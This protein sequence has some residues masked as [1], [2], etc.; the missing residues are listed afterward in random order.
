MNFAGSFLLD[1]GREARSVPGVVALLSSLAVRDTLMAEGANGGAIALKWPNDVLVFDK[2]VA[3]ILSS[4]VRQGRDAAFV[5]GIGV[6]L[7][8]A[9]LETVFPAAA[10]FPRGRAPDPV[11]FG[12]ALGARLIGL[13]G[14]L[15]R[16]GAWAMIEAW[17]SHAWRFGQDITIRQDDGEGMVGRF[18]DV[19][20]QG[21]LLLRRRDGSLQRITTGDAAP[22]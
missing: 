19:D 4:F 20:P 22:R 1:A 8:S 9:P 17:R 7:A 13:L 11:S 3:G 6:N 15:E 18:E 5:I 12:D 21:H 10:V 16:G 14:R 2:K